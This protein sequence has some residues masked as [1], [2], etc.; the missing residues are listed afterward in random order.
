[1][2]LKLALRN[3]ALDAVGG[4]GRARV[5]DLFAGNGVMYGAVWC[6][7][8]GYAGSETEQDK[9]FRHPAAVFHAPAGVVLRGIDLTEWN[10]F[11]FD[12][13]GSPWDEIGVLA[14]KRTMQ[15]GETISLAITDGSA[16]RAMMGHTC[17]A[18]AQLA[19]VPENAAGAHL[20]WGEIG[21]AALVE[22]ARRMG[23]DLI[24][25]KQG[26]G[27]TGSRG[28]WYAMAVLRRV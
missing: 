5:L 25:L 11:D 16:R 18:V 14:R 15:R 2:P 23:G 3:R 28:L 13:Y 4:P 1:M 7:A 20:R 19:G 10:V 26:A 21:R 9:V 22:V 8:A 24:E 12:A 27:G 17:R 6:R